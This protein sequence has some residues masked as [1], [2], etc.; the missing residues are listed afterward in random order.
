VGVQRAFH[1]EPA[2]PTSCSRTSKLTEK[3]VIL[4]MIGLMV[5]L[6]VYPKPVLDR[7]ETIGAGLLL[8]RRAPGARLPGAEAER[9]GE[10]ASVVA[11]VQEER[12]ATNDEDNGA[13]LSGDPQ[14]ADTGVEGAG[15]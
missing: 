4:P 14:T 11:D 5:F 2:K 15:R 1:G 8:A 9:E 6:G 13:E 12:N 10:P 3:L 7:I